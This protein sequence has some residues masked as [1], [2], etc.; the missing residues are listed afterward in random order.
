[1]ATVRGDLKRYNGASWDVL[2]IRPQ[3]LNGKIVV[4]LGDSW[5]YGLGWDGYGLH[6][7]LQQAYP[8][9]VF[10]RLAM[11]GAYMSH[12]ETLGAQYLTIKAQYDYMKAQ[13]IVPDL[14][15]FD[16]GGNDGL[17]LVPPG[18][19]LN[20]YSTS[21][22]DLTQPVQACEAFLD[23]VATDFPNCR[24]GYIA[25]QKAA[26]AM[27]ILIRP[28]IEQ[29][30]SVCR[31]RGVP[32]LDF[33][34]LSELNGA[35]A[36]HNANFFLQGDGLHPNEQG[37]RRFVFPLLEA[38]LNSNLGW[39]GEAEARDRLVLIDNDFLLNTAYGLAPL[40]G[41]AI[42]AGTMNAIAG[43]ANHPGVVD[44]KSSTTANS[45]WYIRSL[46]DSLLLAG[47]E[48]FE[49]VFNLITLAN[50]TVRVGFHDSTTTAAPTDGVF[51]EILNGVLTAKSRSNGT[52]TAAA[53]TAQLYASVWIKLVI[54][55]SPDLSQATF[56][57]QLVNGSIGW[58]ATVA[59]NLPTGSGRQVGISIVATNSGTTAV[60]LLQLDRLL[61]TI[62]GRRLMR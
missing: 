44:I 26:P 37:Y 5:L 40:T 35:L 33:W 25:I 31:K 17:N 50:T 36:S 58:M 30:M 46:Q 8:K 56:T 15:L 51:A 52:E 14:I 2:E 61:C 49:L 59:T 21:G 38:W 28:V 11:S 10:Y 55:L 54:R 41:A 24:V 20:G 34:K 19:I 1:M 13:G 39:G 9:A 60:S 6:Y 62:E 23:N 7:L 18:N 45:G 12:N 57:V 27:D 4:E 22:A 16:G 48:T 3:V 32:V 29:V 42:S 43:D 53:T 47:G